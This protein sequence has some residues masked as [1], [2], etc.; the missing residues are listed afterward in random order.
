MKEKVSRGKW[1]R[2]TP[3]EIEKSRKRIYSQLPALQWAKKCEKWVSFGTLGRRGVAIKE[4][5]EWD[6]LRVGSQFFIQ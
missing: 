5:Y 1:R 2:L 6:F 4:A 3:V